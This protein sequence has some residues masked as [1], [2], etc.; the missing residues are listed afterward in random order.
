MLQRERAADGVSLGLVRRP[1]VPRLPRGNRGR[2]LARLTPTVRPLVDGPR[3][4]HRAQVG[5]ELG[6]ED[7]AKFARH[8]REA[9]T[10]GSLMRCVVA[11]MKDVRETGLTAARHLRGEIYEV[12]ADGERQTFRLL[13]APEGRRS[14]V[15]LAL[16]AFS[17]KT[18]KTPHAK[19][20][21][22]ERRL[23][24]CRR[25]A[26][27]DVAVRR[28]APRSGRDRR[29]ALHRRALRGST[30]SE[31]RVA[32][33]KDAVAQR[34]GRDRAGRMVR[35]RAASRRAA[36]RRRL[37]PRVVR[38][39]GAPP[40][41]RARFAGSPASC[42]RSFPRARW[43]ATSTAFVLTPRT[44]AICFAARYAGARTVRPWCDAPAAR[45]AS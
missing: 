11:A 7:R 18:Q 42:S 1:K 14:Q 40:S 44:A 19:I 5:A 41:G 43:R 3:L 32:S 38:V 22:A 29:K 21:L 10:H 15:L 13:F 20:E 9:R 31:D 36:A 34:N 6:A 35:S 27:G 26:H 30:R 39:A 8:L 24:D 2:L 23:A 33:R 4:L 16:E 12:R 45:R 37:Q 28:G 17:K 25:R